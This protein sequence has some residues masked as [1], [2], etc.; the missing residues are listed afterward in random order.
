[1]ERTS[2]LYDTTKG[3]AWTRVTGLTPEEEALFRRH[4]DPMPRNASVLDVG[5]GAGRFVFQLRD[6]GFSDLV[7]IDLSVRLLEAARARA[8]REG[9]TGVRFLE[10]S[11]TAI[12]FPDASFDAVLALQQVTSFVGGAAD[13]E[14][15]AR[16]YHRVLRPG[17]RLLMSVLHYPA[18]WYNPILSA[19][20]LPVKVLKGDFH[21]LGPG[22]LPTIRLG[23]VWNGRYFLERQPYNHW[24]RAGEARALLENAGFRGIEAGTSA[25][26]AP[27]TGA[28]AS[29]SMLYFVATKG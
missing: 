11:A 27:G 18:R 28:R 1:V 24:F 16:E 20:L 23:N 3:E 22:S 9:A 29:G 17:G 15:A 4:L 8:A 13:R 7:G 25:T 2:E 12:G 21:A 14:R 10:Q 26:L 6:R 5:T 19:A